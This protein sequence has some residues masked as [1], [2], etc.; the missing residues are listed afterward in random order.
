LIGLGCAAGGS[1]LLG[2]LAALA[3]ILTAYVRAAGKAA[4]ARQ[5]Y[6]GPMA[7]QQRMFLVTV[8]ALYC[9]LT[10]SSWQPAWGAGG[11]WGL[12]AAF[13]AVIF[14]AALAT[15]ARRLRR[16]AAQLRGTAA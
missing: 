5:E 9:G 13:L 3:A 10:P 8:A 1:V 16:I 6:C 12:A 4:G 11:Q 2:C 7:K 14:I 15:A